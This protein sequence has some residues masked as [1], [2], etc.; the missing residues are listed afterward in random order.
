MEQSK[1]PPIEIQIYQFL[2]KMETGNKGNVSKT[3][4]AGFTLGLFLQH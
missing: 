4:C 2:Q 3:F 1:L